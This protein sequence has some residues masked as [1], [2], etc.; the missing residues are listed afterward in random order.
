LNS[1]RALLDISIFTGV[2]IG[3]LLSF[4]GLLGR[5]I[6]PLDIFNHFQ[7]AFLVITLTCLATTFVWPFHFPAF[8][9]WGR[10]VLL[11]PLVSSSLVVG[12]EVVR[13]AIAPKALDQAEVTNGA[14]IL[15]VMS[16]NIYLGNWDRSGTA[17]AILD[18]GA[19]IVFLQEYAPNRFKRQKDL[20]AAYPYQTRCHSWRRCTLAILS[21][22]PMDDLQS[23]QLGPKDEKDLIHGKMLGA[24]LRIPG[25]APVR[26]YTVHMDW[27][28]PIA[29]QPQQQGDLRRI[30][31]DEARHYPNQILGG[32]FNSSGWAFAVDQFAAKTGLVRHSHFLPTFPSPNARIK[33]L[34]MVPFLSLDHI[35]AS[36]GLKASRAH[37]RF[38][39]VGDHVPIVAEIAIP[40]K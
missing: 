31:A 4:L 12:P 29:D 23:Y 25:Q 24:T 35:L 22:Y 7:L 16:F 33:R 11:I 26:L 32:D 27:P 38:V 18:Q 28:A 5:F 6:T 9:R 19:D 3:A 14:K 40:A 37:R 10:L 8:K 2:V 20:K 39:T 15:T 36:E 30:L 17:K 21:K 13:W 34:P 1:A